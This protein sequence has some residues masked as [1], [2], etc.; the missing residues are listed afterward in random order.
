MIWQLSCRNDVINVK[1]YMEERLRNKNSTIGFSCLVLRPPY[2]VAVEPFRVT[3]SE[4]KSEARLFSALLVGYV[5]TSPKWIDSE[6]LEKSRTG[7]RNI[8]FI[9]ETSAW[10]FRPGNHLTLE[11][12]NFFF[13]ARS[14]VRDFLVVDN[15]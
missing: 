10:E 3:W 7:T 9:A 15:R 6:G 13:R 11:L 5:Y 2:F 8:A 12:G 14:N 4:R 1:T